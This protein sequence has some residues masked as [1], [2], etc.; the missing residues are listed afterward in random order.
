MVIGE[1]SPVR[2]ATSRDMRVRIGRLRGV[3]RIPSEQP[4]ESK[5]IDASDERRDSQSR[6]VRQMPRAVGAACCLCSQAPSPDRSREGAQLPAHRCLAYFECFQI[7]DRNRRRIT[8]PPSGCEEDFH[9]Q[10]IEHA[11]HTEKARDRFRSR[12]ANQPDYLPALA[13]CLASGADDLISMRRGSAAAEIGALISSTPLRYSAVSL[14]LS[15]PSG[16]A[17]L[18][19]KEP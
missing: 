2:P 6:T 19:S 4:W 18:R 15:T 14:S 9:L 5:P 13:I 16:K 17:M 7:I 10:A 8:S 12:A 11:R 3:R 1:R